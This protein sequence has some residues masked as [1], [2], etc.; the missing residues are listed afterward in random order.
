MLA[1]TIKPLDEWDFEE[2]ARG[3]PKDKHGGFMG[4]SPKWVTPAVR[5]EAKRRLKAKALDT[6]GEH[7]SHAIAVLVDLMMSDDIDENTG[8]PLVDAKT[9]M[10]AATY[11][12]DQVVGRARQGVDISADAGGFQ[13]IIAGAMKVHNVEGEYVDAHPI[14]EGQWEEAEAT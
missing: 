4:A 6:M 13:A 11:I 12:I 10:A 1:D 3:R 7:V 5:S 2:L 8:K 9:R 14:V